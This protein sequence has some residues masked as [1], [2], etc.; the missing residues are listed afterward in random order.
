MKVGEGD[1]RVR[2]DQSMVMTSMGGAT[3]FSTIGFTAYLAVWW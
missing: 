2:G 3:L 1:K